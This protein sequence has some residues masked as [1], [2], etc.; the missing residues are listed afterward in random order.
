MAVS[1]IF[2]RFMSLK[3]KCDFKS[4]FNLFMTVGGKKINSQGISVH[5]NDY[6]Y[7][8]ETRPSTRAMF[9]DAFH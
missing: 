9:K 4:D 3:S 5:I 1:S 7:A 2:P 8:D 6:T